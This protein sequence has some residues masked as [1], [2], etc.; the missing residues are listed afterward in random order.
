MSP[1]EPQPEPEPEPRSTWPPSPREVLDLLL[2]AARHAANNLSMVMSVNL[3]AAAA[4]LARQPGGERVLRQVERVS[5]AAQEFDAILRGVLALSRPDAAVRTSSG[6]LLQAALPLMELAANRRLRLEVVS[7]E[8]ALAFRRPALD[9]ALA[10]LARAAPPAGAT[11]DLRL[12]GDTLELA[13]AVETVAAAALRAAGAAVEAGEGAADG[14]TGRLR[15][16]V[17]GRA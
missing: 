16:P 5:Q 10:L 15:L 12:D 7:G 14:A 2:P 3:D 17:A 8:A 6:E 1:D 11:A 9:A 13:W 4:A